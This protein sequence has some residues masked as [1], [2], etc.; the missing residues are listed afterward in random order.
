MRAC[1]TPL[2]GAVLLPRR[3]IP[4]TPPPHG[5]CTIFFTMFLWLRLDNHT[6][7]SHLGVHHPVAPVA[8]NIW[9]QL[10]GACLLQALDDSLQQGSCSSGSCQSRQAG[11]ALDPTSAWC[12]LLCRCC[13][14]AVRGAC[15]ARLLLLLICLRTVL[16]APFEPTMS[17]S[18][19]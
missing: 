16:P 6:A 11:A 12:L 5:A 18:G 1:G 13:M 19:L 4:M 3:R 17:V 14:G 15:C 2:L 10:P 8:S 9:R 7:A